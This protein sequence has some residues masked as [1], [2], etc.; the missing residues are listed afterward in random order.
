MTFDNVL[1]SKYAV[2]IKITLN[3]YGIKA[4]KLP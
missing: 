4:L 2:A 3:G 1:L